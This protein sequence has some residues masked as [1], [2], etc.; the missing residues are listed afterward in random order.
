MGVEVSKHVKHRLEPQVLDMTLAVTIQR[1]A[2]VLGLA[3]EVEGQHT[4]PRPSLALADHKEAVTPG[5]T[6]QH[7]LG[8]LHPGQCPMEPGVVG[9]FQLSLSIGVQLSS[10][11]PWVGCDSTGTQQ[12]QKEDT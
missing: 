10:F 6:S 11:I 8:S 4:L 12:G 9:E 1:K 3:L 2:K 5:P 7:Q